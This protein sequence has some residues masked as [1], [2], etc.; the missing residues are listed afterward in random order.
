MKKHSGNTGRILDYLKKNGGITSMEAFEKFGA[1]R[2]SAIIYT[3]RND[4]YVIENVEKNSQ[5][6]FGD[7]VRFVEYKYIGEAV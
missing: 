7:K 3:L 6:R 4:G 2:L 5:N 1:T